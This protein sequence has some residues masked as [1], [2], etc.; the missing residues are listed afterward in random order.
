MGDQ[1]GVA[2]VASVGRGAGSDVMATLGGSG[3]CPTPCRPGIS[4]SPSRFRC[5]RDN[6]QPV[7][8]RRVR[9]LPVKALAWSQRDVKLK[10]AVETSGCSV[11]VSA[12]MVFSLPAAASAAFAGPRLRRDRVWRAALSSIVPASGESLSKIPPARC[13]DFPD[14]L[15][16][17]R[18]AGKPKRIDYISDM[19]YTNIY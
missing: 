19:E 18:H 2:G 7:Q 4:E 10:R 12:D 6:P 17:R 1:S 3:E 11:K 5:S 15:S 8:V 14:H 13:A 9:G 16:S